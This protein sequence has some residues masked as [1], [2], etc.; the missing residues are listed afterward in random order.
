MPELCY[1]A[2]QVKL[3]KT[4]VICMMGVVFYQTLTIRRLSQ[5]FAY[6]KR[7][8]DNLHKGASY[9]LN[10]LE[11]NDIPLTEFDV[12]ALTDILEETPNG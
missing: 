10:V 6:G 11:A 5:E 4:S 7:R 8:F 3:I 2:T 12:I 9:L 1:T